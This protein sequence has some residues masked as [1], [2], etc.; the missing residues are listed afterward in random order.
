MSEQTNSFILLPRFFPFTECFAENFKSKQSWILEITFLHNFCPCYS[1][2]KLTSITIHNEICLRILEI[3]NANILMYINF[4]SRLPT[5]PLLTSPS[6]LLEKKLWI[7]LCLSWTPELASCSK[8][9][10]PK[11]LRYFHFFHPFLWKYGYMWWV[12]ILVWAL[13]SSSLDVWVLTN[14][15]ILIHVGK[16]NKF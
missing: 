8:N 2:L 3:Y 1:I 11:L 16:K 15:T 14:G 13:R 9:Q 12:L 10:R 6:H 4:S 5:L 7:S